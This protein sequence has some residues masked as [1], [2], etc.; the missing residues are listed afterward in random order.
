M[1][2]TSL[3]Q[4]PKVYSIA[5]YQFLFTIFGSSLSDLFGNK[6]GFFEY[7]KLIIGWNTVTE[8][9]FS[10]FIILGSL[11]LKKAFGDCYYYKYIELNF[12]IYP[13]FWILIIEF[14]GPESK[15]SLL[16]CIPYGL[17]IHLFW[18]I[19]SLPL[20]PYLH[21]KVLLSILILLLCS[22]T[23]PFCFIP[24]LTS[25]I[26][27]YIFR[28]HFHLFYQNESYSEATSDS[29]SNSQIHQGHFEDVLPLQD[30]HDNG[31]NFLPANFNI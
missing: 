19:P 7:F 28:T 1:F 20:F 18:Y 9:I 29:S 22:A 2:R 24:L 11:N 27:I 30:L 6:I 25:I 31:E 10:G 17:F 3:L 4:S 14:Y 12:L 16:A 21:D 26:S 15:L 13:F 5:I 23:F 8:S